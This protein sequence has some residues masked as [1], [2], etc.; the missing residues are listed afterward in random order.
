MT[1]KLKKKKYLEEILS[2]LFLN[3]RKIEETFG[4]NFWMLQFEDH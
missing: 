2:N 1:T 3:E 4:F